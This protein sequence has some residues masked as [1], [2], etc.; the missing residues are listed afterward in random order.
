MF[1][2]AGL[3]IFGRTHLYMLDGLVQNEDGEVIDAEDAPERLFLVP[4][5]II[6]LK[7]PQKVQRW[8]VALFYRHASRISIDRFFVPKELRTSSKL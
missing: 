8:S 1:S 4:G 3:L 7:V 2:P 6:A 5:S